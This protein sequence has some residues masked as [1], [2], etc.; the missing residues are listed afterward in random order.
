MVWNPALHPRWWDGR[1][2]EVNLAPGAYM[3]T[4]RAGKIRSYWLND[5]NQLNAC[6]NILTYGSK[7]SY[8]TFG[9]GTDGSANR[10][11][12]ESV[13]AERMHLQPNDEGELLATCATR[14]S[15][16]GVTYH[17]V[18]APPEPMSITRFSQFEQYDAP[19]SG[20]YSK[21]HRL[22]PTWGKG[23]DK[24]GGRD[25]EI[26]PEGIDPTLGKGDDKTN[27]YNVNG[28][29]SQGQSE[30]T[31]K[32]KGNSTGRAYRAPEV[33]K[34]EAINRQAFESPEA[35][36]YSLDPGMI[37]DTAA[38]LRRKLQSER[39]ISESAARRTQVW[40]GFD[41]HGNAVIVPAENNEGK[42]TRPPH[43][44]GGSPFARVTMSDLT[45]QC[46]ALQADG[47][48]PV[49]FT[50]AGGPNT[51]ST[52]RSKMNALHWR[53]D[54][55]DANG[56]SVTAWGSV[57]ARP[58]SSKNAGGVTAWR[59]EESP[60][61]YLKHGNLDKAGYGESVRR[62]EMRRIK[63]AAPYRNPKDVNGAVM[64][65]GM[66][67]ALTTVG[68]KDVSYD[69]AKGVG[70]WHK[71]D[72]DIRFD[73]NGEW[74]GGVAK[75]SKGFERLYNRRIMRDGAG[76]RLKSAVVPGRTMRLSDGCYRASVYDPA[77]GR[78]SARYAYFAPDGRELAGEWV[79]SAD[80]QTVH[81]YDDH[82]KVR[83]RQR[84]SGERVD[85]RP[86]TN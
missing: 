52:G 55:D 32:T 59:S 37:A 41:K 3:L 44:T 4:D 36:T 7:G 16:T 38:E 72:C 43:N 23:G 6:Q 57:T 79:S 53:T 77:K 73:A 40:V 17:D 85:V 35:K 30:A 70:A 5:M 26:G 81:Y 42:Q 19:D 51:Y 9:T 24:G 45:R 21:K 14:S 20:T 54:F 27:P 65:L 69:A 13:E 8:I 80:S 61:R 66:R 29:G 47:R 78:H 2:R 12:G 60:T 25:L 49:E 46:R 39:H 63:L 11:A 83:D 18:P 86:D 22:D 74:T 71:P 33:N 67:H 50:V 15:I 48:K 64:L 56:R 10:F 28:F 82:G 75:T 58:G 34:A 68:A 1:W 76:K 62:R 31:Y 84:L